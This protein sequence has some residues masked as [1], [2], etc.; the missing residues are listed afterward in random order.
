MRRQN[1]LLALI[2]MVALMLG[3]AWES[4][5]SARVA[6]ASLGRIRGQRVHL[7]ADIRNAQKRLVEAERTRQSLAATLARSKQAPAAK[8]RRAG[9]SANTLLRTNPKLQTLYFKSLRA[10]QRNNNASFFH[11]LGLSPEQIEKMDNLFLQ[12]AERLM[13]LRWA[14]QSEGTGTADPAYLALQRQVNDQLDADTRSLIGE[15]AFQQLQE[16][17]RTAP[18][19]YVVGEFGAAV[20]ATATP[21][22]AEQGMQLTQILASASTAYQ[23][24]KMA[25]LDT[26]DWD[27][28]LGQAQGV[29]SEPQMMAL[30]TKVA[31]YQ[32]SQALA[33]LSRLVQ[34]AAP[35]K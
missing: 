1:L 14:A 31:S 30:Q 4:I 20:A 7:D 17:K 11:A 15:A 25:T 21:L 35:G 18:V 34:Q 2:A 16:L 12:A 28:A 10:Q 5:R 26:V 32:E 23:A 9:P 22:S 6:E 8:P 13:D 19:N 3:L 27:A 29:L 24:G 33:K